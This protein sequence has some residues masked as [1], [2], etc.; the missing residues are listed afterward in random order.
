MRIL[1]ENDFVSFLINRASNGSQVFSLILEK[2]STA[3]AKIYL[4]DEFGNILDPGDDLVVYE[5]DGTPL[6]VAENAYYVLWTNTYTIKALGSFHTLTGT[7]AFI[8]T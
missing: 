1:N 4:E 8:L 6:P 5:K 7:P 3:T 2:Y